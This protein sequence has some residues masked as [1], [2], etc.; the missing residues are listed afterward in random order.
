[1][2]ILN[3]DLENKAFSITERDLIEDHWS[4][5]FIKIGNN[6]YCPS[7]IKFIF[8]ND[9]ARG[10][11][12]TFKVDNGNRWRLNCYDYEHISREAYA[13]CIVNCMEHLIDCVNQ[14]KKFI[15]K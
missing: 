13:S 10:Y 14:F 8:S 6:K 7:F 12:E 1:M 2:S 9:V 11:V 5:Y 15:R 3:E 4:P